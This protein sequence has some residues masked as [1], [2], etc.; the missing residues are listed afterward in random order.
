VLEDGTVLTQSL[1]IIEYLDETYPE[2]P[3]LPLEPKARTRMRALAYAVACEIHP[4]NNLRILAY[5]KSNFGADD[6]ATAE[7]FRHWVGE[8]FEPLEKMLA[9]SGETGRF[10]HGDAPGLADICLYAQVL[11]NQRFNV[12]MTPFPTIQRI[13]ETCAALPAFVEANPQNQPDAE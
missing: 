6:A 3:L 12:D 11:N 2:S 5:L 8:T 1:A 9:D 7:W 4:V 10:C 13:Y